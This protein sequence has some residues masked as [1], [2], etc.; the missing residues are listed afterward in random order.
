MFTK[1]TMGKSADPL[2]L[3]QVSCK[4]NG[5]ICIRVSERKQ[6]IIDKIKNIIIRAAVWIIPGCY[7]YQKTISV[8]FRKKMINHFSINIIFINKVSSNINILNSA[9]CGNTDRIAVY[10]SYFQ[11]FHTDFQKICIIKRYIKNFFIFSFV[12]F[13]KAVGEYTGNFI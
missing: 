13:A 3:F 6:L 7:Y 4:I 8:I 11:S 10:R 9:I 5:K 2:L 1:K 12:Y